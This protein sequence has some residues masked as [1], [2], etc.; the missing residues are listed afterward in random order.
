MNKSIIFIAIILL[1]IFAVGCKKEK[2]APQPSVS[3]YWIGTIIPT[4][5]STEFIGMKYNSDATVRL[6]SSADTTMGMQMTGAYS[7]DPDSVRISVIAG[8]ATVRFSSKLSGSNTMSGEIWR[9]GSSYR[10]TFAVSK[11]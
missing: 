2:A 10:G 11:P 8:S 1:A 4:S 7:M 3:G 5:G 9:E 6:Y